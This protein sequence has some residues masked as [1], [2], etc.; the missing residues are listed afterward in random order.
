MNDYVKSQTGKG[1]DSPKNG[2][3]ATA[4]TGLTGLTGITV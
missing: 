1:L 2:T 4:A 3:S